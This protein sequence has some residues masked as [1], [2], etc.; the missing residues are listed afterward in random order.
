M[1]VA[2][3]IAAAAAAPQCGGVPLDGMIDHYASLVQHQDSAS[4]AHLFGTDGVIDNPGMK[5]IRGEPA[6][7]AFLSSFKG[8]VVKSEAMT[9]ADVE[10]DGSDWRV[11]GRFHQTGRTPD[12]KDYDVSG[13]FDSTWD[14]GADGWRVRR[15]ATGK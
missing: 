11:T 12:G 2:F 6:I 14:C 9:V 3:A 13:S 1:I 4:I 5:L 15:M 8:G 10:R 7:L